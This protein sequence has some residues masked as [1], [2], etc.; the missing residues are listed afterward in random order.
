MYIFTRDGLAAFASY[1]PD[2]KNAPGW[3]DDKERRAIHDDAAAGERHYLVR[4]WDRDLIKMIIGD[5]QQVFVDM[6]ADY[7]YRGLIWAEHMPK[8]MDD[9]VSGIDYYSLKAGVLDHLQDSYDL[10][11]NGPGPKRYTKYYNDL[12]AIHET[13]KQQMDE[14]FGIA[15]FHGTEDPDLIGDLEYQE[16]LAALSDVTEEE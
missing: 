6:R 3:L 7:P 15:E 10:F 1:E 13:A 4:G 8:I 16:A 12:V 11:P 2:K 5:E 14:R 9:L